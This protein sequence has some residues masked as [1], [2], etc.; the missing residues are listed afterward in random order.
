MDTFKEKQRLDDMVA[1]GETPWEV[2]KH[3]AEIRP[4]TASITMGRSTQG[5]RTI[6]TENRPATS[7]TPPSKVAA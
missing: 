4:A 2:W 7:S 5:L 1:R 3:H 6:T